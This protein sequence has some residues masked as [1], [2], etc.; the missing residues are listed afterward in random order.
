MTRIERRQARI[1]RIKHKLLPTRAQTEDVAAVLDVHH[2]IGKS[3][4]RHEH[5]GTFLRANE[6]DPAIKVI[7]FSFL[8][9][10]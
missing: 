6:G 7:I 3:Q 8:F 2:H 9:E 4:N 1:R 10:V 5:I